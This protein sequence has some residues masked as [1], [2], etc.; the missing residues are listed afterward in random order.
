MAQATTAVLVSH[1]P[2]SCRI[3]DRILLLR[4]G[5]LAEEGTHQALLSAGGRYAELYRMQAAWYR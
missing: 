5:R 4:D 2:G 1:R 3:A